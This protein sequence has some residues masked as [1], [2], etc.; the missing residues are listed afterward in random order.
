M[1]IRKKR[2]GQV[3]FEAALVFPFFLLI[4]IGGIIDFGVAF[5]NLISIQQIAE[6]AVKFA[7]EE[8]SRGNFSD[9]AV[10][11]FIFARKPAWWDGN[12][13]IP[14]IEEIQSSDGEAKIKKIKIVYGSPMYTPFYISM[15]KAAS[16][17]RVLQLSV[18]AACQVPNNR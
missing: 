12:F 4:V 6:D 16:G 17:D 15:L 7:S 9:Q 13:V 3:I 11:D 8:A 1:K 5:Y 14:P 10:R 2:E 18:F